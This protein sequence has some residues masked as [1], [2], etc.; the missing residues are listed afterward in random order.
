MNCRPSFKTEPG[1]RGRSE[2]TDAL[3]GG[4]LANGGV[5]VYRGGPCLLTQ[6]VKT[7]LGTEADLP[8]QVVGMLRPQLQGAEAFADARL[9]HRQLVLTCAGNISQAWVK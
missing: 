4:G 6:I 9:R 5:H 1:D 2:E 8:L 7:P 3:V